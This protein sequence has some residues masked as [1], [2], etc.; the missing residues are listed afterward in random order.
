[1]VVHT[2]EGLYGLG[3]VGMRSRAATVT[4]AIRGRHG[5][6]AIEHGGWGMDRS[7]GR[8]EV[9]GIRDEDGRAAVRECDRDGSGSGDY[10]DPNA[11]KVRLD[12]IWPPYK[13]SRG[14]RRL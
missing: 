6:L 11:G 9:A 2:D 1:V 3:E 8:G 13:D 12:E 10:L 4:G 5:R 14:R 7:A